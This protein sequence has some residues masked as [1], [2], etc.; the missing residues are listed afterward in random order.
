MTSGSTMSGSVL[1]L[2]TGHSRP[3]RIDGRSEPTAYSRT[4]AGPSLQLG[5]TG[6]AGSE[7]ATARRLGSEN[8]AVYLL[9]ADHYRHFES[10]LGRRLEPG[11]FAEV[12][13][14]DV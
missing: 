13:F 5:P 3:A 2:Y 8:H 4:P 11:A 10:V 6:F 1:G 7:L 12:T 9:L 14:N